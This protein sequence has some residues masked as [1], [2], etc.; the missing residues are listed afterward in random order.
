MNAHG[1][2]AGLGSGKAPSRSGTLL[3]LFVIALVVRRARD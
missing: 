3:V 1:C 2:D